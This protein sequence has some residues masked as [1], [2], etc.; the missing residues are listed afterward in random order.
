MTNNFYIWFFREN[1]IDYTSKHKFFACNF[2]YGKV[3]PGEIVWQFYNNQSTCVSNTHIQNTKPY[4]LP[5]LQP[6]PF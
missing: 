3:S 1:V 4:I 2:I 6:Y 5:I